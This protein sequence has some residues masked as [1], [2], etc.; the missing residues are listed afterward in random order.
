MMMELSQKQKQD[1]VLG[2]HDDDAIATFKNWN[3][4]EAESLARGL[5]LTLTDAH[6]EVID[7]IRTHFANVGELRHARELSE[8]LAERFAAEGGAR[9]L[10][11][12]FPGGPVSQGCLLAGVKV[13]KDASDKAFG[14]TL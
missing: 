2:I 1:L 5:Q 3:R 8:V 9:Y 10:F 12:L 11:Q 6:W 14:Y 4:Q 7:F 13:P